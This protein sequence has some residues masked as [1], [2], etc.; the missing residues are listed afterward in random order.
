MGRV[1]KIPEGG[2]APFLACQ[3]PEHVLADLLPGAGDPPDAHFVHLAGETVPTGIVHIRFRSTEEMVSAVAGPLKAAGK[4]VG[5]HQR[6]I[7]EQLHPPAAGD[8][9]D[10]DPMV[11]AERVGH[12]HIMIARVDP[13][14]QVGR[15]ATVAYP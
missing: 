7:E 2:Q 11:G 5:P 1:F 4:I 6:A 14:Q 12:N 13:E 3:R 15:V 9:C 10:M 8:G